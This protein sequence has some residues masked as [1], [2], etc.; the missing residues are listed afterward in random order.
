MYYTKSIEEIRKE[1][2]VS[3]DKGLSNKEVEE[4]KNKYGLNKIK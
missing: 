1:L 4:R 2:D 3:L